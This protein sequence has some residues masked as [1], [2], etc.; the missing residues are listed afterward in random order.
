MVK[1]SGS[2]SVKRISFALSCVQLRRYSAVSHHVSKDGAR[3]PMAGMATASRQTVSI[4]KTSLRLN[5]G[6]PPCAAR[7]PP[8]RREA[9]VQPYRYPFTVKLLRIVAASASETFVS[10]IV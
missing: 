6:I 10:V 1:A 7:L 9:R 2:D 8:D 5:I 3:S 4:Q